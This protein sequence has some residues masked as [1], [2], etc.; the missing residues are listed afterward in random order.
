MLRTNT[1]WELTAQNKGQTVTLCGRVNKTRNLWWMIFIDLRDRY[2]LTQIVFD[3]KDEAN[4]AKASGL[5]TEY[6][7]KV[8]WT[9]N[10][11]PD[12]QINKD[13]PTGEIE[14][15]PQEVEI[16]STCKELPF[17]VNQETPVWEDIRLEYRYLD[18]RRERLKQNTIIRHKLFLE[19][20]N[21]FDK[22]WFLNIETPTLIKNTPEWSREFVVPARFDAWKFFVLPQSPQQLKQI[23]MVAGLDKYFQMARCYR[24]EDPRWDRQPEF[25]QVDMEMSFVEQQDILDIL[26]EYFIEI[27]KNF[28]NK[29]ILANPFPVMTRF[30]AMNNFGSDKPELRTRE[31][32]IH[33]LTERWKKTEFS[34]FQNATAVKAILVNKEYGRSEIE[35][36][37]EAYLKQYWS[38]GL[39]Y[40][41][42]SATEWPKWWLVKFLNEE[43]IKELKEITWAKTWDTLFFQADER[44]KAV[45]LLWMLRTKLLVDLK[46][47]EWKEQELAFWFIVDFPLYELGSD[48]G[49]WAVHHPFTKPK[50]EDIP[51]VVELWKKI[52]N[53]WE[54]TAEEK[55]KL[56]TIKADCYDIILNGN[57][58]W[59]WSIRIHDKDLQSAIFS[60]LWLSQNQIEERFWHLLK[61]FEYGVPPHGG[62]ALGFDRTVMIYQ[63]EP[64]LREV[65]TFPKNQK[66]RDLMLSSP[67]EVDAD[68]L[69][70]LSLKVIEKESK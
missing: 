47:L 60:I 27:T 25:T 50:N 16:F 67:S 8:I 56:L 38:K 52:A 34:I 58:A 17:P 57:E 5:K 4:F 48:G 64:N 62:C 14:I 24:D 44:E 59:G 46:L 54:M 41:T 36:D 40:I 43:N 22:K 49:L 70:D 66:Y 69:A 10:L 65:I 13:M 53:W 1:C 11:R 3:P 26:Q 15:L 23:S 51:F 30:D 63:N 20:M 19:T 55:E 29:T 37:I 18:L 7:I 61:S 33:E 9:V 35:R 21:F 31:L 68:L 45:T 12:S 39:S 42:F 2:G 28:P 32:N 6:V